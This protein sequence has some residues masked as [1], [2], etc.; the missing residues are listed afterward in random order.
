MLFPVYVSFHIVALNKKS[1]FS[2]KISSKTSCVN[3][4][5]FHL[6]LLYLYHNKHQKSFCGHKRTGELLWTYN[7][8]V[9]ED[10]K[11]ACS[12]LFCGKKGGEPNL[13]IN[14]GYYVLCF[15][16]E[17][18]KP[19]KAIT[20]FKANLYWIFCGLVK[21][22]KWLFDPLPWSSFGKENEDS[23]KAINSFQTFQQSSNWCPDKIVDVLPDNYQVGSTSNIYYTQPPACIP[24]WVEK[25]YQMIK[26]VPKNT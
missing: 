5:H 6:P 8:K 12:Q 14:L 15:C 7:G 23:G 19:K 9:F 25:T 1:H 3:I 11:P 18:W 17:A 4:T 21:N 10:K 13:L 26:G 22:L 16:S 20:S 24:K 2:S